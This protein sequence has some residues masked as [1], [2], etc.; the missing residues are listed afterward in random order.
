M[1]IQKALNGNAPG[2]TNNTSQKSGAKVPQQSFQ[3]EAF[4]KRAFQTSAGT[5]VP[6]KLVSSN[7]H[8]N[9]YQHDPAN[10]KL[11]QQKYA[12]SQLTGYHTQSS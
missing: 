3:G 8:Q 5:A 10:M 1:A 6:A 7:T 9:L 11:L 4:D 12:P 2:K